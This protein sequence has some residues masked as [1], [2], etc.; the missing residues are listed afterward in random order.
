M[1]TWYKLISFCLFLFCLFIVSPTPI[2]AANCS[3]VPIG[4]NYSVNSACAFAGTI[5]GVDTGTSSTNTAVL[6]IAPGGSLSILSGQTIA[7]GSISLTGGSITIISGGTIKLRTPLWMIDADA[8]GYPANTTQYAQT[9]A[10]GN[11]RRRNTM[12]SITEVD[13]SD[14][15]YSSTNCCAVAGNYFGDGSDGNVTISSNTSLA[16][17]ADGD[18]VVKEYNTLTINS[19]VTLTTQNRAKG[20]FIYV[21]G[22]A[23]INGTISMTARGANANPT[24][25]GVSSTGLRLPMLKS[26][27]T[28]TL[29][30]ADFAGAGTAVISAVASQ[31]GISGDG[32]IF[33]IVRTGGAGGNR[34]CASGDGIVGGTIASG[35]GGGGGGGKRYTEFS[36]SGY[37]G[38]ATCFSGGSGGGGATDPSWGGSGGDYGGAGGSG[39][40]GGGGAGNPP[41][42]GGTPA[43]EAGTGGV[44]WLIVGGDLTIG[45][46][47]I[48]SADGKKGGHA[49]GGGGGSGGG[50]VKIVYVGSL[51]NSGSVTVAGG[52]GGFY[53]TYPEGGVGGSGSYEIVNV[54]TEGTF[55]P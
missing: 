37:G 2:S 24:T 3:G 45:A 44:I 14:S 23:I 35:T 52:V 31:A 46:S 53:L 42:T 51:S 10:P 1:K 38:D 7:V 9:S 33:E 27:S 13:C 36:C 25:A 50:V 29:S 30:A 21:K 32:I 54:D 41:G 28:E 5:N 22:N 47:G 39:G 20:L 15:N 34:S 16:N 6:I 18:Y 12:T 43:A 8:D 19:G 4:G 40:N 48:I 26:G 11:G 55:C 17:T 49:P